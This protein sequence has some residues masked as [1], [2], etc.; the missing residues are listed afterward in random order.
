MPS[1]RH[2]QLT[3]SR[4]IV[5]GPTLLDLDRLG[6]WAPQWDRLVDSS[7]VPSPFLRS[8]W[9]SGTGGSGR[10][11]LLA[12][13]G[14]ELLG[15]LALEQRHGTSSIR[16]MGDGPLCPDHVDL[17]A[18]PGH[19]PT[20]AALLRQWFGRP[21]GRLVD[22]RGVR[23]GSILAAVL[24]GS[25]R[26]EPMLSAPFAPLPGSADAFRAGLPAQFRRNLRKA[27]KRLADEGVSHRTVRGPAVLAS[28][29]TMR[30]LH[31]AQWEGRSNF[32]PEFDRFLA[33]CT[34][35]VE[36]DE[37]VVHELANEDLVVATVSAFEVAGRVSL[38][39]SARRTEP[40][41]RD[42]TTTLL[43]AIIDDACARGFLEVDF[44]RGEET[45]KSRFT[46][47]RRE[48]LRLVGGKG[49]V[50]GLGRVG[51]AATFHA[52]N[53]AVRGVHFGRTFAARRKSEKG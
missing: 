47:T 42:V 13:E 31:E 22:L 9:L 43:A 37:V 1:P 23:E 20:V 27:S 21:G 29:R 11:F 51:T 48:M 53:A 50:G 10:H 24:P 40:H 45:Y 2:S 36:A 3:A 7:P 4:P 17:V 15:G 35:G 12:V 32:L 34:G 52:T 30:D 25:V 19:E 26:C 33:G 44:L 49:V 38:Y 41:W 5:S 28:L 46:T 18:A 8:W 39:Q 14:A 6:E 16:V